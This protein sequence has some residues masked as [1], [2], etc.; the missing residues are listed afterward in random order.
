VHK[1]NLKKSLVL[2][3]MAFV[4]TTNCFSKPLSQKMAELMSKITHTKTE[5][6]TVKIQQFKL[7]HQLKKTDI[8]IND[9]SIKNKQTKNQI[10]KEK[11]TLD[12]LA[13][14]EEHLQLELDQQQ[15]YLAKLVRSLYNPVPQ[16]YLKIFLSQENPESI[17]RMI[18]YYRCLA[19]K[20]NEAIS[21]INDTLEKISGNKSMIAEHKNKLEA[22]SYN[23]EVK[24]NKFVKFQN[25]SKQNLATVNE[26][27]N[28]KRA[29]LK[30]LI[31]DKKG[32]EKILYR[33]AHDSSMSHSNYTGKFAKLLG[34]L[35]WPTQGEIVSKFG[36]PIE[37]SGF[38]SNGVLI[39]S[40]DGEA[41]HA[42]ANGKVVFADFLSS[43]GLLMIID[44]GS[45]FMS[46]YGHNQKLYKNVGDDVSIRDVI[47]TVGETGGYSSPA[48]YF[49]IRHD[50]KPL[51]PNLW[52]SN[53]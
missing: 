45:G 14:D 15:N 44:H 7:Q 49:A 20:R 12:A 18:N 52:C 50:T 1:I 42:I 6:T 5:L 35:S 33:I 36:A 47:A 25:V 22:L 32:L 43:Y 19:A 21:D 8:I 24:R 28:E 13:K 27:L 9:L 31:A 53:K 37:D 17:N 16:S 34:K 23:V 4:F 38:A 11:M 46:L 40:K 39:A 29:K 2:G 3:L 41:V 48:L 30:K 26:N 10:K 51:N